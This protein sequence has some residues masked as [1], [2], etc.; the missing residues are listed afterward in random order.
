MVAALRV[1][2]ALAATSPSVG[3]AMDIC[4]IGPGRARHFNPDEV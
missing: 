4:R 2:D 1:L 3:V